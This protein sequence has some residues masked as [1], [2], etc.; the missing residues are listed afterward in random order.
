MAERRAGTGPP[1]SPEGT[2]AA[3]TLILDFQTQTEVG[4]NKFR[5]KPP[6]LC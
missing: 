1:Q 6:G 3:D 2:S 5:V 4:E